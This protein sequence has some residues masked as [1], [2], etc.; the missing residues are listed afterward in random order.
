MA[1]LAEYSVAEVRVLQDRLRQALESADTLE[2]A[3]SG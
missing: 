2:G 1:G 3:G